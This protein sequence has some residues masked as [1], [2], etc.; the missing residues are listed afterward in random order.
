LPTFGRPTMPHLMPMDIPVKGQKSKVNKG[1][2][3]VLRLTFDL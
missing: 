2:S 3:L 1:W